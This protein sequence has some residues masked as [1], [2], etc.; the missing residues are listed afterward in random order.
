MMGTQ[1]DEMSVSINREVFKKVY[2]TPDNQ[3]VNFGD[4]DEEGGALKPLK[5][6]IKMPI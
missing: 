1:R 6:R 2:R 4:D 5:I 3:D